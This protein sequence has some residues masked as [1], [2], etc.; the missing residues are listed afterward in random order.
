[1]HVECHHADGLPPVPA[2]LSVCESCVKEGSSWVHLRQCLVCHRTLCCDNSPKRHMSRHAK[3]EGHAVM[4]S[5]EPGEDWVWCYEHDATIRQLDDGG[6]ETYS[7][8][9]AT[10]IEA[11]KEHLADGGVPD[12]DE[13]FH[14]PWGYPLGEWLEYVREGHASGHLDPKDRAEIEAIPG[15]SW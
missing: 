3:A 14:T 15:W 1:M 10:G 2:P 8:F 6:W 9:M 5:V 12:P 11:F 4:R 7:P 13:A